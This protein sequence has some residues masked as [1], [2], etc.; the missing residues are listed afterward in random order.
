MFSLEL[1]SE[2]LALQEILETNYKSGLYGLRLTPQDALEIIASRNYALS[3]YGR[4]EF[5]S[6]TVN[7]IIEAFLDS[8]YIQQSEYVEIIDDLIETFYYAKS[9]ML[10]VVSDDKLIELMVTFFNGKSGGSISLLRER[11]L[12]KVIRSIHN[13]LP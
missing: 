6:A 3:A 8:P 5:G 10:E 7:K 2:R 12:D 4:I 1:I 13:M 11:D 9:E